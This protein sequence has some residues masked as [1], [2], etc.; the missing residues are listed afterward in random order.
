MILKVTNISSDTNLS[1]TPETR[2]FRITLS[3]VVEPMSTPSMFAASSMQLMATESEAAAYT[4]GT[5][6]DV[7]LTVV[8]N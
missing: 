2:N 5:L 6:V 1:T 7:T 4:I 3:E 8:A